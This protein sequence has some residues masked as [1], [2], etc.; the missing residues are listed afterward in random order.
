[1]KILR[2]CFFL[3]ILA[4]VAFLAW[5]LGY[6]DG[7]V[8]IHE[9]HRLAQQLNAEKMR[10]VDEKPVREAATACSRVSGLTQ[11][12]VEQIER[13]ATAWGS[14][15]ARLQPQVFHR[16]VV[17]GLSDKAAA[18]LK[19]TELLGQLQQDPTPL[20]PASLAEIQVQ[21]VA[22]GRYKIV[23]GIFA[24]EIT[25]RNYLATLRK[26][27]LMSAQW[28]QPKASEPRDV[29]EIQ[30]KDVMFAEKLKTWIAP[31]PSAVIMSCV[32]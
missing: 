28:E 27:G 17:V 7:A 18:E 30:A 2:V 10:I 19:K 16:V 9:P 14:K 12:A 8:E 5:S 21:A 1:V 29:L 25:A 31:F 20:Q 23:V 11:A 4:N 3:L 15:A 6:F 26:R 22:N 32:R 24:D 13:D